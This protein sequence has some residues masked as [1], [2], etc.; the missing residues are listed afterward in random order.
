MNKSAG[1]IGLVV[2]VVGLALVIVG[3]VISIVDWNDQRASDR[4]KP[5]DFSTKA[6]AGLGDVLTGLAKVFDA[7]K[8]YPLGRFLVAIGFSM[9]VVGGAIG[10]AGALA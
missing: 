3:V 9:I 7:L 5:G 8:S 10:S 6:A 2:M 1:V 4:G